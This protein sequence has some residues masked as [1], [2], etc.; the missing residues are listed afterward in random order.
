MVEFNE[1]LR[2]YPHTS[3]RK[4]TK[5]GKLIRLRMREIEYINDLKALGFSQAEINQMSE[6]R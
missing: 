1:I 2:F 3:P 4:G 5:D 6:L